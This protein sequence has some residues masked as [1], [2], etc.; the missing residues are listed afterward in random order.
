MER[1]LILLNCFFNV[2]DIERTVISILDRWAFQTGANFSRRWGIDFRSVKRILRKKTGNGDIGY[3]WRYQ[4][5]YH[6]GR[7]NMRRML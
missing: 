4:P 7:L 6:M 3:V 1:L 2:S 5:S